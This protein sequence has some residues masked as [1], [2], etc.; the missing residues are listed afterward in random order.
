M[1]KLDAVVRQPLAQLAPRERRLVVAALWV[2]MIA[3]LISLADWVMRERAR[4]ADT[5]PTAR[6]AL[7][8]M[9]DDAAE[10]TRLQRTQPP[11][12][13]PL[14]TLAQAAQVAG[15]SRG[16]EVE[17]NVV[18]EQLQAQGQG[19]VIILTDWLASLH[20]VQRLRPLALVI[21]SGDDDQGARFQVTL[22]P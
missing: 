5:L 13:L 22:S 19:S 7:V 6:S 14:A 4:L 17:V 8:Q 21:E 2:I 11:P 18:G 15:S 12:A 10:L 3:A 1:S 9:Q 20:A 16:L